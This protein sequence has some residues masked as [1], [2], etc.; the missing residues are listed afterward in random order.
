MAGKIDYRA[1][2][3]MDEPGAGKAA[4]TQPQSEVEARLVTI[5]SELLDLP[6]V[7]RE[8]SF[9]DLGGTSLGVLQL[10][11]RIRSAFGVELPLQRLFGGPTIAELGAIIETL[12]IEQIEAMT[13]EQAE[14]LAQDLG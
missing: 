2:A 5:W 8:E 3:G 10:G 11:A 14:S 6:A 13:D 7:G 1:L 12:I 9:F 4:D